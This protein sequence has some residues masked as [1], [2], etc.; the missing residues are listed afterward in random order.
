LPILHDVPVDRA[1]AL[2]VNSIEH[3]AAPWPVVFR[4]DLQAECEAFL[5]SGKS[6]DSSN[7]L[8]FR[9]MSL[10]KASVSAEKLAVLA[11]AWARS[12]THFCPTLLTAENWCRQPPPIP[13]PQPPGFTHEQWR[14]SL[15]GLREVGQMFTRELSARGVRILVGHDGMDSEGAL[16]EMELLSQAGVSAV[17][18]L[19]G[20]TIY[21]ATWLGVDDRFGSL[22]QGKTADILILDRNPLERMENIRSVWMVLRGGD[23]IVLRQPLAAIGIGLHTGN[24]RV[25]YAYG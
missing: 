2:G 12:S 14:S 20:A 8:R 18:I 9:L 22:E 15:R 7:E 5:A 10:G 23:L 1:L 17:E 13:K 21:P 3:A 19:R 16:K 25:E 4:E 24:T 6:C 11:D